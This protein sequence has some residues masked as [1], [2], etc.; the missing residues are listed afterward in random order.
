MINLIRSAIGPIIKPLID[1][2]PDPNERARAA[3]DIEKS[4]LAAITSLVQGQ[5]AINAKEAEHGSWFVAG[6]R[7]AVGWTCCG[8]LAWNFV[9]APIAQWAAFLFGVDLSSAPQLDISELIT[10]LLGML[11]LGGLRTY[12]KRMGVARTGVK[13]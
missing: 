1:R 7:P 6:W 8:G 13:K 3:E 2:I 10:I 12:E 5:L 11:G 9:V 4:M